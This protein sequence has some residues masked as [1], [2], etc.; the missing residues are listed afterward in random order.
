MQ[1]VG[2]RALEERV[3]EHGGDAVDDGRRRREGDACVHGARAAPI[4]YFYREDGRVRVRHDRLRGSRRRYAM[5]G[6]QSDAD[7]DA[8]VHSEGPPEARWRRARGPRRVNAEVLGP[9]AGRAADVRR[10]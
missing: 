2:L 4:E 10:D 6:P 9:R 1:G 8:G 7:H 3:A 5:V